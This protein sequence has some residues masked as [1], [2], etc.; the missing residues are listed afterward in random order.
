ML[1]SSIS[2]F[3]VPFLLYFCFYYTMFRRAAQEEKQNQF[4]DFFCDILFQ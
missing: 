3:T 2:V 4:S 1:A